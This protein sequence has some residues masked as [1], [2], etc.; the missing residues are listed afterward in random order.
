MPP[1]SDDLI[2][3]SRLHGVFT[4]L[5]SPL[6]GVPF[7]N[8]GAGIT[9]SIT[10]CTFLGAFSS[11]GIRKFE[12]YSLAQLSSFRSPGEPTTNMA[13]YLNNLSSNCA[14]LQKLPNQHSQTSIL[15]SCYSVE[16]SSPSPV[17][18]FHYCSTTGAGKIPLEIS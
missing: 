2:G 10:S 17:S 7:F 4:V 11:R 3:P 15:A 18:G 9:L 12:L 16:A 1:L 8:L 14:H 6:P 5:P 13:K